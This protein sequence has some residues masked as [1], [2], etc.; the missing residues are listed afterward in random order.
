MSDPTNACL[1]VGEELDQE[2]PSEQLRALQQSLDDCESGLK[3]A[4]SLQELLR[5][6]AIK[7]A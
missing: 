6:F 2:W 5:A 1:P 3:E 7:R 4:E